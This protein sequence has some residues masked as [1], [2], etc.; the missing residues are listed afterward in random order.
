MDAFERG[1][2]QR[3]EE[4]VQKALEAFAKDPASAVPIN[5][6][7]AAGDPRTAI[8]MRD[9]QSKEEDRGREA[10]FRDAQTRYFGAVP[11]PN[12]LLGNSGTPA[13]QGGLGGFG[14]PAATGPVAGPSPVG[15][16]Q[17]A[18]PNP[19]PPPANDADSAFTEMMRIDPKRALEMRGTRRDETVKALKAADDAYDL[20]I[21]RLSNVRDDAGYQALLGE[22]DASL[23]AVGVD[24]RSM[25]PPNYP[26]PEGTRQL[27]MMAL[28]AKDQLH[29]MIERDKLHAYVADIGADN[30]RADRNTD[31]LI[32]DR[33]ART[34]IAGQRPRGGGNRNGRGG[35]LPTASTPA[36]AMKLPPGTKFRTPDGKVKVRP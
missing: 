18:A 34:R 8:A 6:L 19:L 29:A 31:S 16:G 36:E 13:P 20:A 1:Q 30:A 28:D 23:R 11:A 2:K 4:Q 5:A 35:G 12:A 15:L 10:K 3:K 9:Y 32:A 33:A 14:A 21:G 25:V 22:M 7:I 27:L 24:I 17:G 26:G